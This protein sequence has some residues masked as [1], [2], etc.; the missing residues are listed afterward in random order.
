MLG[1]EGP[2]GLEHFL[3][4]GIEQQSDIGREDVNHILA[5]HVLSN[6]TDPSEELCIRREVAACKVLRKHRIVGVFDEGAIY[7][8][9]VPVI[10]RRRSR[11]QPGNLF[12]QKLHLVL[13][14]GSR[15]MILRHIRPLVPESVRLLHDQAIRM[16]CKRPMRMIHG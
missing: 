15:L 13:K 7:A 5:N 8:E 1:L 4:F 14:L 2:S 3:V 11:F 16:L 6:L 12:A 10:I 9:F